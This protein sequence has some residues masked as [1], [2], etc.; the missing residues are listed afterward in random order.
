MFLVLNS[1][2]KAKDRLLRSPGYKLLVPNIS[3]NT[4]ICSPL[5]SNILGS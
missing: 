3:V 4:M 2:P 1:P 5:A